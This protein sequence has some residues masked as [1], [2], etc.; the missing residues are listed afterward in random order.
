MV[1]LPHFST[2]KDV[3]NALKVY[4]ERAKKKLKSLYED[5]FTW[6]QKN[7]FT[8]REQGI[9]DDSHFFVIK[10]YQENG[11]NEPLPVDEAGNT[12]ETYIQYEKVV[13]KNAQVYRL[14]FTDQEI[15]NI[16]SE[17]NV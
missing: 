11:A 5:R 15:Q 10:Q 4:P 7:E 6:V 1:G 9:T 17:K 16:L 8:D 3:L 13:D 14:G 2:K 12:I